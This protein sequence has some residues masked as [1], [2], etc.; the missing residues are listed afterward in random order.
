MGPLHGVP[1][2]I[3]DNIHVAGFPNTAGTPALRNFVP[4]ANAPVAQ[5]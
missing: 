2:V 3:K 5:A 4:K 1:I